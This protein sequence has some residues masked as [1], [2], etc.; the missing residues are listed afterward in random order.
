MARR[1]FTKKTQRQ[2]WNRSGGA[3]EGEGKLYGLGSGIRCGADMT[4]TGVRYDHIDPDANSKDNS[5]ENCC[6]CCPKCH[7]FKTRKRDVPMIA[8]T[9][10]QQDRN[11]GIHKPRSRPMPGSRASR[12]K[13]K[14]N[15]EVVYRHA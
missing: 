5:L 9:V 1:E 15:G 2:A 7:D 14:M 11:H 6:A 10:R 12:F 13:R 4:R 3:C 8:K